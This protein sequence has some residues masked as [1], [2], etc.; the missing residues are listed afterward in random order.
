MQNALRFQFKELPQW[1]CLFFW[2][3]ESATTKVKDFAVTWDST[4]AT[5]MAKHQANTR[6]G[7]CKSQGQ[8][9]WRT[10]RW[11][12]FPTSLKSKSMENKPLFPPYMGKTFRIEV[13]YAVLQDNPSYCI[14]FCQYLSLQPKKNVSLPY[15]SRKHNTLLSWVLHCTAL[16]GARQQPVLS[17]ADLLW[18]DPTRA[19]STEPCRPKPSAPPGSLFPTHHFQSRIQYDLTSI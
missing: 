16:L 7:Q 2:N 8:T 4:T 9:F 14:R 17:H 19:L 13:T 3:K 5:A 11:A 6:T 12:Q 10:E 1:W 18:A 15:I